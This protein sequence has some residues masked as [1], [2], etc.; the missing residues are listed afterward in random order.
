MTD[1]IRASI[2]AE[3]R[4]ALAAG[5]LDRELQILLAATKYDKQRPGEP[6]LMDELRG[7]KAG[8]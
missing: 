2:L 1:K 8:A 3:F 4:A 7:I 6:R 5:D